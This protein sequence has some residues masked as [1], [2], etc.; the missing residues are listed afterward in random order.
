M[1][2]RTDTVTYRVTCTWLKIEREREREKERLA[3][4]TVKSGYNSSHFNNNKDISLFIYLYK[5]ID[6]ICRC[7]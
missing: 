6:L 1:D 7:I 5:G 2:W 3:Y 4:F